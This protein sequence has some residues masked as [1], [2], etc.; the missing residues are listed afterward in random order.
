MHRQKEEEEKQREKLWH[1]LR[2]C[3]SEHQNIRAPEHQSISTLVHQTASLLLKKT[4][5][6]IPIVV[7]DINVVIVTIVAS[8][9]RSS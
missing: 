6:D 3:T 7:I 8:S 9:D 1:R 2:V 4:C 5:L